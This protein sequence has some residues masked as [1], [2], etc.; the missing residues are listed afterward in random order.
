[1]LEIQPTLKELVE[2]FGVNRLQ[3]GTDIPMVMRFYTYKQNLTHIQRVS[4]FLKDPEIALIT[5]G[6]IARLLGVEG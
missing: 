2:R 5:G 3:W 4:S 6:N 1:M